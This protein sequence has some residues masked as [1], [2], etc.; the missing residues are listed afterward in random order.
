MT[1]I[2]CEDIA[3]GIIH[4]WHGSPDGQVRGGAAFVWK[5]EDEDA[6]ED[7]DSDDNDI[8]HSDGRTTAVEANISTRRMQCI[9]GCS[10]Y[11]CDQIIHQTES[12]SK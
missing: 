10:W 5:D 12:T 3:I 4:T 9:G 2:A 1:G 7:K 8:V 11:M 6:D